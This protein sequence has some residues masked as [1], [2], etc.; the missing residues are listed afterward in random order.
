MRLSFKT[1]ALLLFCPII[2][3]ISIAYTLAAI[4]GEQ[5]ILREEIVKRGEILAAVAAKSAELPFLTEN[6]E[7]V[8]SAASSLCEIKNVPF[9]TFFTPEFDIIAHVGMAVGQKPP[10][11]ISSREP[12]FIR[13]HAGY[14]EFYGPVFSMRSERDID[15]FEEANQSRLVKDHI[16][17]VRIGLS[18]KVMLETTRKIILNGVLFA[19]LLIAAAFLLVNVLLNVALKPLNALFSA[20]KDLQEGE[21]PEVPRIDTAGEI[22]QLAAEFNKMSQAIRDREL[23]LM[24]SRKK[25]SELFERVEHALFRLDINFRIMEGNRKLEEMCDLGGDFL[26]LLAEDVRDNVRNVAIAG[27]LSGI[28]TVI[29]DRG[30]N[31]HIIMLSLYPEYGADGVISGFDGHFVDITEKKKMEDALHQTQRLES[32]GLLAGGV[33]HDFNNILTV[34]LGYCEVCMMGQP[35]DHPLGPRIKVIT[36]A[37]RRASNLTRQL[38]AFSRKQ[39]ME[40]RI[41]N[42]NNLIQNMT[43]M[44]GRLIGENVEIRLNLREVAGNIKADPGQVEQI[45]MNLA[46]NARDAMPD[47]GSLL[48]ETDTF[49]FDKEYCRTHAEVLPGTY[50]MLGV[51]DTGHGLSPG[52]KEKIFDP[53][54]TTKAKGE[55]TGLGLS[56]VYGI[57]KQLKGHIYVYSELG[58]GTTFKIYFPETKAAADG[59]DAPPGVDLP[60]GTETVLVVDDEASIPDIVFEVLTPLGYSVMKASCGEDAVEICK[61]SGGKIDLLLTDVIMPGMSCRAFAETLREM[62]PRI[63]VLFMSGYTDDII[64]RQGVLEPNVSFLN[65]PLIPSLL[66]Q[67]IREILDRE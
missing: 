31:Q 12:V 58:C 11:D 15:I 60:R 27:T 34:I 16:G 43:K 26:G 48:I 23:R 5:N 36:D 14:F 7:I 56:T 57:M 30:H 65:K 63:K 1:K 21:Y 2:I 4:R 59:M 8:N 37:A 18:K 52:I 29:S 46:V 51:T 41:F 9:V 62:H 33:A 32:L 3:V 67:K 22:G 28:E 50:V 54:F 38:L 19:G 64:A 42:L 66:A 40:M 17:W 25:I 53:F 45:I 44:L 6:P 55:G 61:N 39:V 10:A 13:E 20:V 49:E 35:E 47:G 24:A